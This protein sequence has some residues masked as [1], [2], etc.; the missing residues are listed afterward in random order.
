MGVLADI[1]KAFQQIS[2]RK[3]DRDMLRFYWWKDLKC[4]DLKMYR[5]C[6]V[7]FGVSTS[8]FILA[9]TLK[10]LMDNNEDK[11]QGTIEKL[12]KTLYVDNVVAA[13]GGYE[14]A[15]KF[16]SEANALME[17]G[18]FELRGWEIGPNE[19][20]KLTSL[21][22]LKWN[23]KTDK[24]LL[25]V[26]AAQEEVDE[27]KITKRKILST[28]HSVYDPLG[29]VSPFTI[30]PRILLQEAW[31]LKTGWDT[32]VPEDMKK[33]FLDWK[34]Q[35]PQLKEIEVPRWI[36]SGNEDKRSWS[37]HVFVDSSKSALGVCIFLRVEGA[38]SV[39]TELVRASSRVAPLKEKSIPLLELLACTLGVRLADEVKKA[40]ELPDIKITY[41]CDS[42]TALH[43]IK[44]NGNWRV[45]VQNRVNEIRK[46]S[47]ENC[48]RHI[49]GEHNPADLPSRGCSAKYLVTSKW[50]HGPDWLKK[51]ED[52]F[53][54]SNFSV[55]LKEVNQE[56]KKTVI[57]GLNK[58]KEWSSLVLLKSYEEMVKHMSQLMFKTE[59]CSKSDLIKAEENIWK[60]VQEKAF[61]GEDDGRLK[62]LRAYK[63]ED[64]LIKLKTRLLHGDFEDNFK[65]PVILPSESPVVHAFIMK[66]HLENTHGGIQFMQCKLR[67][68]FWIINSRRTIRM[69]LRKCQECQRFSVK[70]LQCPSA[71]L[72]VDRIQSEFPFE[73]TGTDLTGPLQLNDG[74]KAWIIIF[75]C[76][77]YRAIHLELTTSLSTESYIIALRRFI[78]RRGRPR[79]IYSDNGTN[80]VGCRNAFQKIDWSELEKHTLCRPIQWK[81]NPPSA[82]WWGGWYERLIG[83]VKNCLR[84]VLG[85]AS[86]SYEELETVLTDVEST[87]NQRPLTYVSE[88]PEDLIPLTPSLI[89]TGCHSP[90]IPEAELVDGK[91]LSKRWEYIQRIRTDL[92]SR[93]KKEYLGQM[94]SS[95][96]PKENRSI[97]VGDVVIVGQENKKR[98]EWPIGKISEVFPGKDGIIRTVKVKTTEG[99][100][101]RPLQRIYPMEVPVFSKD[102]TKNITTKSGRNI[103][104]PSRLTYLNI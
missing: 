19:N 61:S 48:W 21:L 38:N 76:A 1:K 84:R 43:W 58:D 68:Q 23:V 102:E 60:K 93:Y 80:L 52:K 92:R 34:K 75:T 42:S 13:C 22:G 10:L 28:A 41:W 30:I 57:S 97:K 71:S 24:I 25:D 65:T 44:N 66:I 47:D 79:V 89:L 6:R 78:N 37:L 4:Q 87:V 46:L 36:T 17:S 3:E 16:K 26:E 64:G 77:V 63:G 5:H 11:Y 91:G 40:L 100:L 31:T 59:N 53:P 39:D 103:R 32:P 15:E 18:K 101:L 99:V 50:C 82:P 51:S 2:V 70:K 81:L 27:C 72:P 33:K 35:I 95:R 8:P 62:K 98:I 20:E 74:R 14:D 85:K 55:E 83:I 69:V 94:A 49:P 7:V 90:N 54:V 96:G 86:L 29:I 56:L 45:F 88:D 104:V 67:E 12:R 73:V 9:A